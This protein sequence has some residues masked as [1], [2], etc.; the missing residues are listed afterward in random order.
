MLAM[1]RGTAEQRA[2]AQ[3]ALNRFWWPSLMMF[4]PHDSNSLHSELS[5]KWKIKR[6]TND[7]LRRK[8]ID[9]TVPQAQYLGLTIPDPDLR[10]N[11]ATG[12]WEHGPIDWDEFSRVLAGDGP[13]NRQRM[14]HRRQA[15]AD[16][17][18]VREAAAAYAAKQ[19]AP[20]GRAACVP[21]RLLHLARQPATLLREKGT[22][23]DELASRDSRS[24]TEPRPR[25]GKCSSARATG[26]PIATSARCTRTT[27][28]WRCR[29][30]AT[31]T[32]GAARRC[33]S[34]S[35]RRRPSSPPTRRRRT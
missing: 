2:M 22:P 18:W 10:F 25:S 13:C 1:A 34:G 26:S 24:M 23:S 7:G 9:A 28:R 20:S 19:R 12:H 32:R 29:P 8:F 14:K 15:E 3:D 4:G 27:R 17:A 21:T 6:F 30:R 16:G 11:E 31:S 35:S 33:R 5:M